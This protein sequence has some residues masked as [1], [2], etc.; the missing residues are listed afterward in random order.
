MKMHV[1]NAVREVLSTE[2]RC[3]TL[4]ILDSRRVKAYNFIKLTRLWS[5]HTIRNSNDKTYSWRDHRSIKTILEFA[6]RNE[7]RKDFDPEFGRT[8]Y[9]LS[10]KE[11]IKLVLSRYMG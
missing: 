7:M 11:R 8:F 5:P 1:V 10:E 3:V 6:F 2:R 9:T 4:V